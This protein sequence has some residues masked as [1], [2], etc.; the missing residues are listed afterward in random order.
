M[1]KSDGTWVS[2]LA[3][4][5]ST[6]ELVT[7]RN[8]VECSRGSAQADGELNRALEVSEMLSQRLTRGAR[9]NALL[10][11][12][13]LLTS[14]RDLGILLRDVVDQT[15]RLI[16]VDLS[17]LSLLEGDV[18][19][20]KVASGE[21]GDALNDLRLPIDQGFVSRIHRTG[22]PFAT[23]DYQADASFE[24]DSWADR[25]AVN[26]D[27]RGLLGV[28][29]LVRGKIIGALFAGKRNERTF[30]ADE[31][32]LVAGL[33]SH[34]AVAIERSRTEQ[35]ER[36]I[37][38]EL[39]QANDS[40]TQQRTFLTEIVSWNNRMSEILVDGGSQEDI[41]A[42]AA[43]LIDAV[44]SLG[45]KDDPSGAGTDI[46]HFPIIAGSGIGSLDVTPKG[47]F[48]EREERLVKQTAMGLALS[49][50]GEREAVATTRQ[51]H[52]RALID[53]LT[54]EFSDEEL[55]R[56]QAEF[57][58]IDL[59]RKQYVAVAAL[60]A[61]PSGSAFD[62]PGRTRAVIG[63][64]GHYEIAVTTEPEVDK[65]ATTRWAGLTVGLAGEARGLSALQRAFTDAKRTVEVLEA[66]ERT[67]ET[68][69]CDDL[70]IYR[71]LL[72]EVGMKDIRRQ[73][74][75]V[76]GGLARTEDENGVPLLHTLLVYLDCQFRHTAAAKSLYIH[77]NTLY[78][79]LRTIDRVLGESWRKPT[80]AMELHVLLILKR[81]LDRLPTSP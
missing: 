4:G 14:E 21:L 52:N 71:L 58:G 35:Y 5:A 55:A 63:H 33:A 13:T 73:F 66:L 53:V 56:K 69:H 57:T 49:L 12:T 16:G 18:Y 48:G 43:E 39:R 61:E 75:R 37:A 22:A 47:A 2:L 17:Y 45:P 54:G 44:L 7:H 25:A 42:E 59:R 30:T 36:R 46:L 34:A 29:L 28:P 9:L 77:P 67:G 51:L 65:L 15:R 19:V 1:D 60:V 70:G 50:L 32:T 68:L 3:H 78:Q 11:V 41:L 38:D 8:A 79:R 81:S 76:L 31:T 80:R 64:Q 40:L 10:E 23:D 72:S 74:D 20:I 26:E 62:V 24:H 27:L 6:Q